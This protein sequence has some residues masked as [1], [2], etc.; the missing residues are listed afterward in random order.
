M[1]FLPSLRIALRRNSSSF[2]EDWRKNTQ[3]TVLL[4]DLQELDDDLGAGADEHLALAGLLGVVDGLER[5]VEHG[6]LGHDGG[7]WRFSGRGSRREVSVGDGGL[8]SKSHGE[9]KECPSVRRAHPG[10]SSAPS[11]RAPQ[12]RHGRRVRRRGYLKGISVECGDIPRR[13]G[14]VRSWLCVKVLDVQILEVKPVSISPVRHTAETAVIPIFITRRAFI[15]PHQSAQVEIANS[16]IPSRPFSARP[17]RTTIP[18]NYSTT[19]TSPHSPPHH[20]HHDYLQGMRSVL[21]DDSNT[22]I[23]LR[24]PTLSM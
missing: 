18:E 4:H 11:T 19:H 20:R 8:A 12:C 22:F 1:A 21:C 2:A 10:G 14:V 23:L 9:R 3:R 15:Q 17:R 16:S 13:R 24:C 7:G 6:G 5:I